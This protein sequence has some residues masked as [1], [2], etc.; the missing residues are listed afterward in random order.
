MTNIVS[1]TVKETTEELSWRMQDGSLIPI[2]QLTLEQIQQAKKSANKKL[3]F[4]YLRY[5]L[6]SNLVQALDSRLD[7]MEDKLQSEYEMVKRIKQD[8]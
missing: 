4:F 2:S 6:F 7:W 8:C 5:E 3:N 1:M